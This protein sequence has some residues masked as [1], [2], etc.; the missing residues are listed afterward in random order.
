MIKYEEKY[1]IVF[2]NAELV[3][4]SNKSTPP[5][6]YCSPHS[7]LPWADGRYEPKCPFPIITVD[8]SGDRKSDTSSCKRVSF[9][10]SLISVN[11]SFRNI[12]LTSS[13]SIPKTLKDS[14]HSFSLTDRCPV[15]SGTTS[16]SHPRSTTSARS[17]VK[18]GVC[19]CS[20]TL[21]ISR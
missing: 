5:L 15:T 12:F 8:Y 3:T 20:V 17:P 16:T 2:I 7:F 18:M 1:T 14:S 10:C 9:S 19:C 6:F 11:P 4:G 21:R 13:L